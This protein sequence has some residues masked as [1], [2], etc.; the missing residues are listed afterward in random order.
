[1]RPLLTTA[2]LLALSF[3]AAPAWAS[4]CK[5]GKAQY[6]ALQSGMSYADAVAVLGCAGEEL[7][8][9]EMAGYKTVMFMWDG[10]SFGANMNAMFQNDAMV[11]KAQFGLE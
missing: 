2:A 11:S 7:S 9:S 5:V 8:S 1:V 10:N 6:D 4:D 3:L